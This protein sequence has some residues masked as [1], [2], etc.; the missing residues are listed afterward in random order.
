MLPTVRRY[1]GWVLILRDANN[2]GR[3]DHGTSPWSARLSHCY[4]N[5]GNG[6]F[7][8]LTHASGLET[9]RGNV[10]LGEW[11]L[12]TSTTTGGRTCS[13]RVASCAFDNISELGN[14]K[15]SRAQF[16]C[17]IIWATVSSPKLARQRDRTSR[18]EAAHR[19]VAAWGSLTMGASTPAVLQFLAGQLKFCATSC[20]NRQSL[21]SSQA[22]R[23]QKAIGWASARVHITT[24][25]GA[26][27]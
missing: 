9:A 5:Q 1:R 15:I 11:H 8:D 26:S 3:Y 16:P 24:E 13:S 23:N 22:R 25:D 18:Q 2:D 6:E 20:R 12:L 19:G 7:D 27:R 17:F 14:R 21:D 10:W 4:I